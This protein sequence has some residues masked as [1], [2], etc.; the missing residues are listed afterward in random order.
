MGII[1][2]GFNGNLILK[3]NPLGDILAC[4]LQLY[5]LFILY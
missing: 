3:L 2:I 5:G 1:L 4:L